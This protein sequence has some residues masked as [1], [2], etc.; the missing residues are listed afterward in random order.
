MNPPAKSSTLLMVL[1]ISLGS[2]NAESEVVTIQSHAREYEASGH[3][4]DS[5]DCSLMIKILKTGAI[6]AELY[7][8]KP[9]LSIEW[10]KMSDTM[11]VVSHL[12]GGS[13]LSVINKID[14]AWRRLDV[15][16]P[17]DSFADYS[18]TH[19]EEVGNSV[20]IAYKARR[21]AKPPE[22]Y[23]YELIKFNFKLPSGEICDVRKE[24]LSVD[25][26]LKIKN[27]QRK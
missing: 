24:L 11:V 22:Y 13:Y 26:Y 20:M 18:V 12:A 1:A 17:G 15:D 8:P 21:R 7:L 16:P 6:D 3:L 14:N 5:S 10:L 4:D 2:V 27:L 23:W 19:W 9:I 25:E